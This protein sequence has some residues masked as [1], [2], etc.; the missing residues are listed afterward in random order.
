MTRRQLE[1]SVMEVREGLVARET[2]LFA[3]PFE[4]PQWRAR[5]V[6]RM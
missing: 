1:G 5:R 6:E 2:H 4:P 3:E